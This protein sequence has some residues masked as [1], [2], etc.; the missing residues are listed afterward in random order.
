MYGF[1]AMSEKAWTTG[2]ENVSNSKW[3]TMVPTLEVGSLQP[4]F[5][6]VPGPGCFFS[7][8]LP[9]LKNAPLDT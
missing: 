6:R 1:G 3:P 8:R 4:S 5:T 2:D 7:S 9:N